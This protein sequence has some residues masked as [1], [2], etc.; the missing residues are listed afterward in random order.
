[1][2]SQTYKEVPVIMG[3]I[4]VMPE[5]ETPTTPNISTHPLEE[6]ANTR[7][8]IEVILSEPTI[9]SDTTIRIVDSVERTIIV[10]GKV[11][12]DQGAPL[13]GA[14]IHIKEL[15]KTIVT[16]VEGTYS[17]SLGKHHSLT[18]IT[19][20]VGYNIQETYIESANAKTWNIVLTPSVNELA[21][22]VVV[23]YG[24]T[25]GRTV[26]AGTVSVIRKQDMAERIIDTI[27]C[28]LPSS[29]SI[30][31]N[32]ASKGGI[33]QVKLNLVSE[34]DLLLIDNNGRS[35]LQDRFSLSA[36]NAIHSFQLPSTLAA[37][38][39]HIKI[40]DRYSKRDFTS[41]LII[42]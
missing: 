19:S 27:K 25:R 40:L 37:G 36:K 38:V 5:I 7:G 39:Y 35:I 22:V 42:Q 31:P 23:G 34:F 28:I 33:I 24:T 20:Y 10:T 1:M 29:L 17:V 3:D 26:V 32:P 6:I 4:K 9:Q 18:F 2:N 8:E 13:P 14:V 30:F 21:G 12:N 41:K 16:N 11:M 15:D